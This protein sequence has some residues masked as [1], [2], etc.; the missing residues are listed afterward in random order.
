MKRPKIEI[1]DLSVEYVNSER[2]LRHLAL[3]RLTFDIYDNELLWP[4]NRAAMPDFFPSSQA[5][6][7]AFSSTLN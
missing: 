1:R 3:D 7:A 6:W 2:N 5:V 4:T